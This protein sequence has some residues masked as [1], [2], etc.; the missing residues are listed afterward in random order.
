M[1]VGNYL[2]LF[3]KTMAKVN[4]VYECNICHWR[5]ATLR[6]FVKGLKKKLFICNDCYKN[7]L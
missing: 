2:R 5:Y 3:E 6:D 4:P 7:T 1:L